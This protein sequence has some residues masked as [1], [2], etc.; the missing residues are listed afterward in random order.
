MNK[1]SRN[2]VH[3]QT[4]NPSAF[5][6]SN[7]HLGLALLLTLLSALLAGCAQRHPTYLAEVELPARHTAVHRAGFLMPQIAVYE[8]QVGKLV[9]ND[10]WSRET[11]KTVQ[12]AL[13]TEMK[14]FGMPA[15]QVSSDDP[16]EKEILDLFAAVE[17]GMHQYAISR[18]STEDPIADY[19]VGP[20]SAFMERNKIDALWVV[21][22]EN[23]IPTAGREAL[24][25][26]NNVLVVALQVVGV[27]TLHPGPAYIDAP[28]RKELRIALI[29]NRGMVVY[30][31]YANEYSH[32]LP[33]TDALQ[34]AAISPASAFGAIDG[35]PALEAKPAATPGLRNPET[36]RQ[37]I[38]A[39]AA[40]YQKAVRK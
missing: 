39:L 34:P 30:Y 40:D 8:E 17:I 21:T 19:S 3:A 13:T 36:A 37:L 11:G 25:V 18:M 14:A 1:S 26:I 29:D 15:V 12:E 33:Q 2:E 9:Y 32:K 23:L 38:K 10:D 5:R 24:Q 4:A 28:V 22:G 31:G 16:E 6:R 20:V 7:R 35:N 27:L